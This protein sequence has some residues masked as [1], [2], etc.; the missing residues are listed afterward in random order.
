MKLGSGDNR[1]PG[2]MGNG[3][4]LSD[5]TLVILFGEKIDRSITTARP[6]EPSSRMKV[7]TSTDGGETFSKAVVV[8]DYYYPSRK[9]N[10][11]RIP[12]L[13]VSTSD[14]VT[15]GI[16]AP[17]CVNRSPHSSVSV[18][19]SNRM[20]QSQPCGTCGGRR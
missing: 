20:P 17:G 2:G 6:T 5:G 19:R 1:G 15:A 7:V 4:V 9:V 12:S 16:F 14:S 11:S 3:V 10:V 13:A 18:E 8:G